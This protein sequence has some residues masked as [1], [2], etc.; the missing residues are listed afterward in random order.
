MEPTRTDEKRHSMK[1]HNVVLVA[2]SFFACAG[3]LAADAEPQARPSQRA[4]VPTSTSMS[5][6]TPSPTPATSTAP[7]PSTPD[8]EALP[9]AT[10]PASPIACAPDE[11]RLG[12]ACCSYPNSN[13]RE[14][15]PGQ[16]IM[17]CRGPRI[18]LPCKKASDCDL[19]C[20]C[21]S[22]Q[23]PPWKR[24]RSDLP[25]G[26]KGLTGTCASGTYVGEWMC[27]LDDKGQV[28]HVILD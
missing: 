16:Q 20:E 9:S 25:A 14:R 7:L 27:R 6:S 17:S 18:G 22:A 15:S 11:R 28:T 1:R 8:V 19:A 21:P 24:G 10:S 13:E 5:T 12:T 2:T 26:T 4:V 23:A 3:R